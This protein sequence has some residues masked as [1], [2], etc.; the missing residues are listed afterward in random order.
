MKVLLI[1]SEAAPQVKIGGLGDITGSLPPELWKA[2]RQQGQTLEIRLALPYHNQINVDQGQIKLVGAVHVDSAERSIPAE[3]FQLENQAYP[4]Y[5]IQSQYTE[6]AEQ[7]YSGDNHL[8]GLK[9]I[10]FS[11]AALQLC[12]LLDWQPDILHLQDWHT[13]AAAYKVRAF[14]DDDFFADSKILLTVHNLPYLGVGA[15]KAMQVFGL[16]PAANTELPDW[17]QQMPLPVGLAYADRIN[18]VSPGY[19]EEMLTKAFGSGLY[20][21]IKKRRNLLS[22]ILNGLDMEA[23]NPK[24][25]KLIVGNYS[26]DT[27]DYKAV[28]KT[29]LQQKSGLPLQKDVPLIGLVSRMDHQKGIDIAIEALRL[30]KGEY[31]QAVILGSGNAQIE[32]DAFELMEELPERVYTRIGFQPV[33]AREIYAGADLFLIPSRYEPCGLTQMISMRYGTVP[34]ASRVGGLKDTIRNVQ[35]GNGDG[36]L[37]DELSAKTLAARIRDAFKDFKAP[38]TWRK[39]QQAGMIKDF[40]WKVSADKYLTLYKTLLNGEDVQ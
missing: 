32:E 28:N 18:T 24:T 12:R 21:F 7:V 31:W 33:F 39:I 35:G 25:D 14:P 27:L 29:A 40:S 15:Q 22:G 38:G 16:E 8:D 10:H 9:Y 36:Y 17:A 2:A 26:F 13:A 34:I 11:L 19:A 1:A 20:E 30:L 3:I 5:L 37:V 6:T 23:W 4:T